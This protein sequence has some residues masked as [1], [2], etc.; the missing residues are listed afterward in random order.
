MDK[1]LRVAIIG[2]GISGLGCAYFLDQNFDIKLYEKNNYIGGHSNTVDINYGSKKIAVDTGFIVFNHQTYPNLKAFFALLGVE[3]EKSNMSFAV[4]ISNPNIEYAGTNINAVFAQRKNIFNP[5]FWLMLKDILKFNRVA[6]RILEQNIKTNY[7]MN[8]FLEDLRVG[9]YF[10]D[11]YLL[12]MASAIWSTPLNKIGDYPAISF[13]RFF[14]NHGLLTVDQQPQWFTVS[15]GSRQYVQKVCEN[16]IHK[17]SLNDGVK[18]IYQNADK[19]WIVESQ[20]GV[21][22]F[23]KVVVATHADQALSFID[24]PTSLQKNILSSF[25]FQKNHAILHKDSSV[26][27]K[28]KKA[29]AS[30]VYSHNNQTNS[31]SVDNDKNNLSVSY[32]MNNLQNIDNSYPLFVT[33]NPNSAINPQDIFAKFEYEHP[34]FNAKAVEAQEHFNEIQGVDNLYFCGAYQSFGFHEDGLSSSIRVLNK[35]NI[36][37]PWQ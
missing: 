27:P 35:M 6:D 19:K 36:K 21:E 20:K 3:F 10:R 18:K 26:M 4:K 15:N 34:I 22:V 17:V 33:L 12:P 1:N 11:Y 24:N 31:Q 9:Q 25:S 23:D 13:V 16:F 32:W 30:W 28:C 7:S 29:W 14:K 8:N 2:S 5:K 37:T